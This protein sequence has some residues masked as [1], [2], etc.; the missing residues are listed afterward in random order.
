M[1][2]K[3]MLFYTNNESSLRFVENKEAIREQRALVS[4]YC[5]RNEDID[6]IYAT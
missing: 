3:V 2:V 6:R 4:C 5:F 1:T